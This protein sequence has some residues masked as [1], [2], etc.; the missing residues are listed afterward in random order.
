MEKINKILK[1]KLIF[2]LTYVITEILWVIFSRKYNSISLFYSIDIMICYGCIVSSFGFILCE[3]SSINLKNVFYVCLCMSLFFAEHLIYLTY[4]SQLKSVYVTVFQQPRLI[5]LFLVSLFYFK[6]SF[7]KSEVGGVVGIKISLLGFVSAKDEDKQ[8]DKGGSTLFTSFLL[9]VAA[10]IGGIACSAF[11]ILVKPLKWNVF[12]YFFISHLVYIFFDFF[13]K[14]FV[15]N[16]SLGN[17]SVY[18]DYKFYFLV[19]LQALHAISTILLS[20]CYKMVPRFVFMISTKVTS[21]FICIFVFGKNIQMYG[22]FFYSV[23]IFSVF[24]YKYKHIKKY[25]FN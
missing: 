18:K 19:C 6:E 16:F 5:V 4:Q 13:Y 20:Y 21:D 3:R 25:L 2:L 17:F 8:F 7:S 11:E 22:Y 10:L 9:I 14:F 12:N 15:N 23:C 24:L 1:Y